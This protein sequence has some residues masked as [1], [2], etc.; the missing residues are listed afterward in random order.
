M[1]KRRDGAPLFNRPFRADNQCMARIKFLSSALIGALAYTLL[2]VTL[3][4]D[5]LWAKSQLE[6]QKLG[7]SARAAAIKKMNDELLLERSALEKD[8]TII[9]AYA[10]SLEYVQDGE[11]LLKITGLKPRQRA[12]YDTGTV[13]RE[14][15]VKYLPESSCKGA[16]AAFFALA[17]AIA[18]L[19]ETSRRGA[20]PKRRKRKGERKKKE[21]K[22]QKPS[23]EIINGIRVQ[24]VAEV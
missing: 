15:P 5:G 13:L 16:A 10:R 7:I 2:S 17:L 9:A 19:D 18:A 6:E 11:K 14:K 23:E 3:G 22:G 20:V 12:L 21:S 8:R 24:E 1:A 4:R